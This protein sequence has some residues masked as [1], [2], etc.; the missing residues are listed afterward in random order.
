MEDDSHDNSLRRA[1]GVEGSDDRQGIWDP[2]N[3]H[4]RKYTELRDLRQ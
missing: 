1:A 3:T 2:V 4:S